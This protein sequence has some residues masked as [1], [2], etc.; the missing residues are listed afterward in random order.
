M[1]HIDRVSIVIPVYN[2]AAYLPACL[3]AIARQTVRPY[4]VIVVDNNSTDATAAIAGRYPFVLLLQEP[5]QGV[6]YA[7]DRGFNAARG[8]I[9]GRIDADTIV[10]PDWVQSLIAIM[11]DPAVGAVTGRAM[12][13]DMALSALLNRIDLG[14]RRYLAAVLRNEVALQGANMAVRRSV[15]QAVRADM[16]HA[17]G[18]HEDFDLTVHAS[19]RGYKVVFDELLVAS[20]AYRQAEASFAEFARYVRLSP[21]TYALHGLSSH[22]YMYPVVWLALLGYLPLKLLHRG[23]DAETRQFSWQSAFSLPGQPRVNPATFVD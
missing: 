13:Y 20:L 9:I 15:W 11:A 22:R 23:Y 17:S 21:K 14:I 18:M 4:E 3:E 10:S 12:Y 5:R 19:R 8:E 2:E 7:R 16:C 6:V 1:K